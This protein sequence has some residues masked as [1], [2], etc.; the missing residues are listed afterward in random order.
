MIAT[1]PPEFASLRLA[2]NQVLW[3][4]LR[5]VVF[6]ILLTRSFC[7]PIFE[8]SE[9]NLG[10]ATIGLGALM[11]AVVIAI[12]LLF[13]LQRPLTFPSSVIAI[14]A[15][16]LASAFAATLYAPDFTAAARLFLVIV[17]YWAL[18]VIPFFMFRQP[19][20]LTRFIGLAMAS[21]VVPSLYAFV[22]LW[23]GR[24]DFENFRLQSTFSHPNIFA[25][26]LVLQLGLA[27]YVRT[28][29]AILWPH[30]RQL[31]LAYIPLLIFFLA[32]TKTRSA[33]IACGVL[34]VF[35]AVWFDRR[36]LLVFVLA[37]ILLLFDSS[38]TGRLADLGEGTQTEELGRLNEEIRLNSFAWREVLW[39]S[40]IPWIESR[41]T[42][43]Y[44]LQS[45]RQLS[46]DFFPLASSSGTD[47]HNLYVQV[48]FEMG[49]VGIL[50]LMW[51][52]AALVWRL[53]LGLKYDRDAIL[54]IGALLLAYLLEAYSDN[55][56]YYLS[57]NWY[58]WFVLGSVCAAIEYQRSATRASLSPVA[59]APVGVRQA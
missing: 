39:Q 3:A 7:D 20:D 21:S 22:D 58:F 16:F 28:S 32:L 13:V 23:Q 33:W 30:F 44:G 48:M 50:A 17:S 6:A 25:F 9:A 27:L 4:F 8:L 12:A 37:P 38:I 42:L 49:V 10:G 59:S 18:F 45:F 51:L 46:L 15:P 57:F 35:Y 36:F 47:S 11:N 24:G 14:H 41:P 53:A 55:M 56:I 34:F 2:N 26:Y 19:S 54:V 31:A 40:A 43:G 29:R 5:Q 52:V 1:H